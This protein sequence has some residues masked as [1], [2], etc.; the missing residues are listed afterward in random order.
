ME[1]YSMCYQK[2]DYTI[3]LVKLAGPNW[4]FLKDD[5]TAA[6]KVMPIYL[7]SGS[8]LWS[9]VIRNFFCLT[10]GHCSIYEDLISSPEDLQ[11]FTDAATSFRF[12]GYFND[13]CFAKTWP[14]E[15][16]IPSQEVASLA[17]HEIHPVIIT[18]Y[19]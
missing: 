8:S 15:I 4:W 16:F 12:G 17:M 9:S 3:Q 11:C 7:I 10:F 18:A 2:V 5:I 6:F 1:E 19:L 14:S 13:H